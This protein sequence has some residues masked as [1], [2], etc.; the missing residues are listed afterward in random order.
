MPIQVSMA[1]LEYA[2][3]RIVMGA[4]RKVNKSMRNVDTCLF[5]FSSVLCHAFKALCLCQDDD[6]LVAAQIHKL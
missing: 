3:D 6:E 4:E 2:K 1:A 5:S